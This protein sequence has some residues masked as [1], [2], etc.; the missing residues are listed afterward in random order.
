MKIKR[1]IIS[2]YITVQSS[3]SQPTCMTDIIRLSGKGQS[4]LPAF[5]S[6]SFIQFPKGGSV[7]VPLQER[8]GFWVG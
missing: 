8:G 7:A 4:G 1:K 5:F 2:Q 6:Q 3:Q